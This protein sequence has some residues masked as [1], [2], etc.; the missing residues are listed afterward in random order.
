MRT[1]P[2]KHSLSLLLCL[3]QLVTAAAVQAQTSSLGKRPVREATA[4][5]ALPSPGAT[6]APVAPPLEPKPKAHPEL[7]HRSVI[8]VPAKAPK[9][10][11]VGDHI[12]VIVREQLTFEADADSKTK[13]DYEITSE[14]SAFAKPLDGGL[15]ATTF[16]RGKPNI[17]YKFEQSRKNEADV[18]SKNR[19]VT[20]LTAEIIDIKPNGNLVISAEAFIQHG[21]EISH[22]TFTGTCS[23]KKLSVDDSII[24]T[25]VAD[26]RIVIEN[27]GSVRDGAKSGWLSRIIDVIKP[28]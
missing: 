20:R 13:N 27:K 9:I 4:S 23:K 1:R 14:I 8:A 3:G 2:A 7:P 17:D 28:F 15:G 11:A 26:K 22:M 6:P 12:T 24:S 18:S 5:T 10:Y 21:E 19:L 16:A 25:D